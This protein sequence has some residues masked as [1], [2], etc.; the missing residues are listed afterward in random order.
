MLEQHLSFAADLNRKRCQ[1]LDAMKV[2]PVSHLLHPRQEE[3]REA[4]IFDNHSM[5]IDAFESM[6]KFDPTDYFVQT[7]HPV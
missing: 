6:I 5:G 7:C 4:C 2:K 3:R 1:V